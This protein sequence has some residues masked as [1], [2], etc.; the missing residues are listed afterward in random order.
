VS[1]VANSFVSLI[2]QITDDS[3]RRASISSRRSSSYILTDP[4]VAY[5]SRLA[6]L[7]VPPWITSTC[8]PFWSAIAA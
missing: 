5:S 8:R 4:L 7:G 3:P 6:G 2:L 1:D